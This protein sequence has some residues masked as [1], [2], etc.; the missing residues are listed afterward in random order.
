M[1]QSNSDADRGPLRADQ[2][3]ENS[4]R[5]L[6]VIC[7]G[8]VCG[9]TSAGSQKCWPRWQERRF[10]RSGK[11]RQAAVRFLAALQCSATRLHIPAV[12]N[13]LPDKL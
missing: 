13:N 4:R 3:R 11:Y 8:L 12:D 2:R 9:N 6:A 10:A 1:L 5:R 7:Q